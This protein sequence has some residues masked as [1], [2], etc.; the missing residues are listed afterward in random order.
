MS[1]LITE[2]R[3]NFELGDS[4]G[5]GGEGEVFKATDHQ[6]DAELAIKKVPQADFADPTSFY[7][8]CKKLYF[9]RH[10]NVVP[11]NY[12]CKDN[13]FIFLAMPYFKN[14]SLKRICDIR[15]LNSREIIR[16]SIQF[17]SGLNHIHSK[18]LIHF[19]VKLE[20]IL[21]SDADQ[22]LIS[23]FGL[24]QYTG[25]YGFAQV[26]GTTKVYAPPELFVQERHNNKYDIY[27]AGITLYRMCVGDSEFKRQIEWAL[28]KGGV[29]ADA[30]FM[31]RL[32]RGEFPIRNI[33]YSHTPKKLRKVIVKAIAP[34]PADRYNTIIDMLNDLSS[35]QELNEWQFSTD[36]LTYEEWRWG[37]KVVR[38]EHVSGVWSLVATKGDR[39]K[40]DYCSA[41]LNLSQKKSLS[42]RCLM[43]NW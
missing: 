28:D 19:D 14:G 15:F 10:R 22:A 39:R 6:L 16:Y 12:G 29:K 2:A 36:Y 21:I 38:S 35:I 40:R 8:E 1:S 9:S 26:F 37:N 20:N 18:G 4:I 43:A 11:I 34:D 24:A 31:E 25:T 42:Y 17:L 27:Q 13:D 30:H 5:G 41:G 32:S 7:Q 33:F 23:D 3:L